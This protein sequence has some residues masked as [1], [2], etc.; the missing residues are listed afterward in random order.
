MKQ[1]K[2]AQS[3]MLKI[4]QEILILRVYV[5][6]KQYISLWMKMQCSVDHTKQ[7]KTLEILTYEYIN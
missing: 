1:F 2:L 3:D 5:T 4:L 6:I 7:M